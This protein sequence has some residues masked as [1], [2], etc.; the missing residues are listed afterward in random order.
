MVYEN[1]ELIPNEKPEIKEER[2]K[3]VAEL[4][5]EFLAKGKDIKEIPR[6]K[7]GRRIYGVKNKVE[8]WKAP[9]LRYEG[10]LD[11]YPRGKNPNSQID[12]TNKKKPRS[13]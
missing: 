9:K 12:F 11:D 4:T 2:R 8:T 13:S 6:G 5:V 7:S 1:E 10:Q 3:M